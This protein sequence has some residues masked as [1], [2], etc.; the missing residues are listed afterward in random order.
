MGGNLIAFLVREQLVREPLDKR[1]LS[2]V[3][4]G[5][6]PVDLL[7]GT[8]TLRQAELSHREGAA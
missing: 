8:A 5:L 3:A 1:W 2:V 4:S 6:Q 7:A